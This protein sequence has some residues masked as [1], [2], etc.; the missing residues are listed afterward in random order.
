MSGRGMILILALLLAGASAIFFVS[1]IRCD[2]LIGLHRLCPPR[3][4]GRR[5]LQIAYSPNGGHLVANPG[6]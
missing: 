1:V 4:A 5:E 6:A 3:P 2:L